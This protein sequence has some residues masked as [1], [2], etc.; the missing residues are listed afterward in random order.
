MNH[1]LRYIILIIAGSVSL[2]GC[3]TVTQR[4]IDPKTVDFEAVYDAG[5]D[6][7]LY[8]S[9][10]LAL[11]NYRGVDNPPMFTV[12]VTAPQN[13]AV[14]RIVA[15]STLLN[16]VSITQETLRKKGERYTFE[17]VIKWKYE[18]LYRL[19]HQGHIDL[20][21]TCYINDEEIDVKNIHLNFRPVNECL[22]SLL[23]TNGDLRDYRWLF[24]AYVNE[25]H[26]KIDGI[27]SEILKQGI[28]T[29]FD[30]AK[31]EKK[32]DTQM[33]GIWYYALN[34]G[35]AYSSI[36]CTS[37][38]SR[39]T[40]S[41]YIRFFDDVYK[42]RQA[43]CI[44]AC[45]FFS[46]IMRK[47]G[48]QPIIFVDP[49]HAYLGYYTDKTKKKINLLETTI[50]GWVNLPELETHFDSVTCQLDDASFNKISR[51]LTPKELEKYKSGTMT[52]DEL[53][54]DISNN[55]F[56]RALDYQK[57]NYAN[58]KE[59]YSD[60]SQKLYS[61]IVIDEMRKQILPIPAEEY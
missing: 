27:L 19:R 22:M 43:N 34:R 13:N 39:K 45:V 50:T 58:N 35:L 11:A 31:T 32:T 24:A 55:L 61:M 28:V 38:G 6:N 33:R 56:D 47:V 37:N 12:S 46:S 7:V 5:F 59:L 15:D 52:L 17:P 41:Q 53:K 30:G 51:Y 54:K 60:T 21:F 1:R 26:P 23:D 29:I 44:D 48:L 8:P 40:N 14:L 4:T 16:Y 3:T 36:S 10:V 42:N 49:C 9:M 25:D 18:S 20:T 57:E 2:S